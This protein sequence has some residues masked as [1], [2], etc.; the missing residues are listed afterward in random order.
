MA[1][2]DVIS[3]LLLRKFRL[4]APESEHN[5]SRPLYVLDRSKSGEKIALS[6]HQ[7]KLWGQ[8][9]SRMDS[10]NSCESALFYCSRSPVFAY[11]GVRV[12]KRINFDVRATLIR[13]HISGLLFF[14]CA[15]IPKVG[16][17]IYRLGLESDR[18]ISL[19][20][21]C[22]KVSRFHCKHAHMV[23]CVQCDLG[24]RKA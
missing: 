24:A 9:R 5:T 13:P 18:K 10:T 23:W 11:F 4:P 20:Y 12:Y 19:I 6:T 8:V 14:V 15:S 2:A 22:I 16:A 17:K 1:S 3:S 21:Y 7:L